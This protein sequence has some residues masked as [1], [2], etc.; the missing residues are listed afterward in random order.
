MVRNFPFQYYP[1]TRKSDR[2]LKKNLKQS[3]CRVLEHYTLGTVG[4]FC[5]YDNVIGS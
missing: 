3:Q 2:D 4:I 5:Y 1:L